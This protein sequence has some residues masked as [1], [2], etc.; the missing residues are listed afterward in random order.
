LRQTSADTERARRLLIRSGPLQGSA[1]AGC[2]DSPAEQTVNPNVGDWFQVGSALYKPFQV[3][4][5]TLPIE[6]ADSTTRA[7]SALQFQQDR[8]RDLL[9]KWGA[10]SRGDLEFFFTPGYNWNGAIYAGGS[11]FLPVRRQQ[12]VPGFHHQ[13]GAV[14]LLHAAGK[15]RN[16]RLWRAGGRGYWL[17]R[18]GGERYAD[19]SMPTLGWRM[20]RQVRPF[21]A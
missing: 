4:A 10:F 2:T 18:T 19:L 12:L 1:L 5:V 6:G 3:Y 11:L 14:L 7:V 20:Y 15:L 8:R 17:R 9:N 13:L 21:P 16:Y